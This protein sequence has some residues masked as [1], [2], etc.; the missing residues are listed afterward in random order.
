MWCYQ[1][2]RDW[3]DI[4]WWAYVLL[5]PG[6]WIILAYLM[7]VGRER[8]TRLKRSKSVL[9]SDVP[10]V[11]ILIPARDEALQIR[12]CIERVMKQDYPFYEIIVINDRSRD[13]TGKILDQLAG[14]NPKLKV[15]HLS[16]L[17][18]GWLGKCH[19]LD[20]GTQQASGDW[21]FFVDSDVE[22]QPEAL[23]KLMTYALDRQIDALSILTQLKTY[24][25]I[26]KLM[27][28]LLAGTWACVFAAD[29][30]NEDSEPDRA[31]ANG[32]VFL[33][34]T[35]AYRKVGGHARVKD[36]I[37]EDVELMRALKKEGFKTR[38][39]AGRHLASTRMHTRLGQMFHGWAR[40]FAGTSRGRVVPMLLTIL[41][42][43][44]CLMSVY[45][46][47]VYGLLTHNMWW[48]MTGLIH[49]SVMTGLMGLVW[50]WSGNSPVWALCLPVSVPIQ[51]LILL[52][53]V[54]KAWKG[55]IDW[56]GM[57]I[58]LR[59]TSRVIESTNQGKGN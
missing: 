46:A 14:E 30:T 25:V 3:T 45:P 5:G 58:D 47:I 42:L 16:S 21:L 28:P 15:L 11:S 12:S 37:V 52:F 38:F 31:L 53:A 1:L 54:Q 7:M 6:A 13:Q 24:R 18:P 59:T 48:W 26:E 4:L 23:N 10:L 40:I 32:Q 22:L 57:P 19:A 55:V 51:I 33:I 2:M 56:R 41:F 20:R 49:W 50:F 36:R 27:L 9:P 43:I 8:M 17:E 39:L 35:H 44:G 34:R 29:Q